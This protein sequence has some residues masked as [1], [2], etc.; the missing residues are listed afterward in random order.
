MTSNRFRLPLLLFLLL[1]SFSNSFGQTYYDMSLGNYAET[2]TAWTTPSTNSWSSVV[3][4]SA[5]GIPAAT[6][7]TVSSASFSSGTSGGVQNGNTNIQFLSTG[8]SDNTTAVALELNLNFTGRNA[9]TLT[10]DAA[11]VF[12]TTGNRAGTLRVYYATNGTTWT[13]LTGTNLPFAVNNNVSKSA[14]I[15]IS[16]PAA[17]NNQP[18]VK[19]RF[20]YHNGGTATSPTGSRPKISIDNVMVSAVSAGPNISVSKSIISNLNYFTGSGPSAVDTYNV[21]GSSLTSD[22]T[23]NASANFEISLSFS[24]NFGSSLILT[25]NAGALNTP[26]YVRLVTG[27]SPNSYT[28]SITHSGGDAPTSPTVTLSGTVADIVLPTT[29]VITS[30]SPTSPSPNVNFSV[31]IQAQDDNQNAQNVATNTTVKLSLNTGTGTLAGTLTGVILAGSNSVIISGVTYSKEELD[32]ILTAMATE[33]DVLT[34]ANSS[35]INVVDNTPSAIIKSIKTGNWNDPTSWTCN[36]IP[37][38]NDTVRIRNTHVITVISA[39]SDQGCAKLI[40]DEGATLN[41]QTANFK[42]NF[43]VVPV[44]S[45]NI[46]LAMGNPSNATTAISNEN[47]YLLEKPQYVMSYSR[48]KATSNWVSW[49]LNS[50]S[51]GSATRQNDFRNDTSLPSGWYQVTNT[52]YTGSGFDRGHMMPSGDRTSSVEN[53]SATFF[54]TNMIPQAPDNNQGP[55]EA[56]ESYLR[57]QLSSNQEIYIISGSYGVGGTGSNGTTNTVAGGK[58]TVPAQT[59]KIAVILTNGTDD[60]NR[61]STTTRVIAII[62]PNVQG[63]RTND[64]RIYRT[65][66]DAIETATGYNFLSNVPTAIQ[67]VIEARVDD[68]AN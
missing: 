27:L 57:G 46:N 6:S 36:C 38:L 61:V 1:I 12:N 33:G 39:V 62:M 55:W 19:L 30:I 48:A 22:I 21:V 28:G 35:A 37:A 11:T 31:N 59:F 29:L 23:I 53:N 42:I 13:E 9:G 68:V 18:T 17:L 24:A 65:S 3:A 47:N 43:P 14:N 34:P 56:L 64:W 8:T 4:T 50:A 66:V 41:V 26:I 45:N 51:I 15:S 5:T 67:D 40:V 25:P 44:Q 49:Y 10:F 63:I 2:F 16:L 20:Y 54:M 58:I 52:D 32:I 60:V 7:T